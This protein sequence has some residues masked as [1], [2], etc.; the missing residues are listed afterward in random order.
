MKPRL[1]VVIVT[2][3]LLLACGGP[4]DDAG[5]PSVAPADIVF[6]GSHII[7]MDSARPTATGVAVRGEKIV[8]VG[9]R[10]TV[11]G[12]VGDTTRVVDLG[13][14]TLLPGFIDSHGHFSF[15]A[16]LI[17]FV[18]LSSPPVG[19][20]ENIDDIIALISQHIAERAIPPGEWVLGYGYDDSLLA[21]NRH[22]TRDDLDKASTDHPIVLMHV[23]GHLAAVNS[24]ALAESDIG[25]GTND[26]PGGVIR[27]RAGSREPNGVLEESAAS[28]LVFGRLGAIA[29]ERFETLARKTT[30]YYASFGITTVQDGAATPADVAALRAAAAKKPFELDIAAY[31]FATALGVEGFGDFAQDAE[32]RG[33][34]RVAGVKFS[35]DGSPQGRTA[36]LTE[37]Y[38][39]GPEGAAADYVAYPTTEPAYY[40]DRVA[41]LISRGVPVLVHANGDAAMDLMIEG[42]AEA[43]A[44]GPLPDHRSVIIHA[45]LMRA[46]QVDRAAELGI[47]PSY[48]SAHTFFWGDWHRKSFGEA[49]AQNI[50]P[51]RWAADKGVQFT[52]HND[53]PVV[54]PDMMRLLWATVNRKTRS[55]HV[56]GPHQRLTVKEALHAM[57]LGGAYQ[58]F[59]EANKGSI[60]VGKQADLVVLATDPLTADP[61]SLKDIP[62]VATFS[63]GKPVFEREL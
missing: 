30:E 20:A 49:R 18:N 54:P 9:D 2:G 45:Q 24:A 62:I 55:G 36:W 32:Y 16:R 11:M 21:E 7:T 51:T 63:R 14:H 8:A 13:D 27:R 48:F 22:P 52:V 28:R 17:D 19:S 35:L 6:V 4:P 5:G 38:T 33:G 60:S 50:S 41:K 58:L 37:P 1:L 44:D 42:V 23:S 61:D 25:A 43:V 56:I 10:A 15:T 29:G 57:T 12:R 34:I 26:P 40:K 31:P 53:A 46:D 3:A 59:E 39:E 47:V